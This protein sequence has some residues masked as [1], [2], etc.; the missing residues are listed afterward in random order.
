[1]GGRFA[2]PHE[3]PYQVS[4]RYNDAHQCGGA[5][6]H[7]MFIL[8]AAHCVED[9]VLRSLSVVAG[10][11]DLNDYQ[12][13]EQVRKVAKIYVHEGYDTVTNDNDVA[14]LALTKPLEINQYIRNVSWP[15]GKIG[16]SGM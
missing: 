13:S 10:A 8:T 11:H 16:W 1:M 6:I 5:I 2:T 3:F 4:L 7:A 12:G 9:S 14:L 15:K